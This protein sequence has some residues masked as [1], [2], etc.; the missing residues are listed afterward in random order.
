MKALFKNLVVMCATMAT[1]LVGASEL[2]AELIVNGDF[3]AGVSGFATDYV[4][5]VDLTVPKRYDVISN[6]NDGHPSFS[7]IG[8]HTS[9]LGLMY[10][11]NGAGDVSTVWEQDL[12]VTP[13][14]T[15][16]FSMW[17]TSVYF[18]SPARLNIQFNGVSASSIFALTSSIGWE[19][20]TT[21]WSSGASTSLTIRFRDLN[22]DPDGNDFA[23]DDISLDIS[24]VPEP[25]SVILL[26]MGGIGLALSAYRRRRSKAVLAV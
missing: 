24:A 13:G 18:N 12:L 1:L 21:T 5:H 16:D 26:S 9:G 15:Y 6:P 11:A 7:A 10:V 14:K 23:L 17:A 8:D 25:A 19:Q 22:T 4:N 20:F 3:E 2:K